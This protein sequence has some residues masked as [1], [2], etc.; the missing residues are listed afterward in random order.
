[1]LVELVTHHPVYPIID[2]YLPHALTLFTVLLH[3]VT[4]VH[5]SVQLLHYFIALFYTV[6]SR[7][8]HFTL[9]IFH[10]HCRILSLISYSVMF[11]WSVLRFLSLYVTLLIVFLLLVNCMI[12]G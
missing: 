5:F 7:C 4:F 2:R 10:V 6:T 3:I 12:R 8:F 11:G 9:L 1:V